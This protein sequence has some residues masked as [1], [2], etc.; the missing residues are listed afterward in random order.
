VVAGREFDL[1]PRKRAVRFVNVSKVSNLSM[2][3]AIEFCV[4]G[5]DVAVAMG[6][7][8]DIISFAINGFSSCAIDGGGSGDREG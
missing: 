8:E 1:K 6:V 7:R 4:E 2:V 3:C 5:R